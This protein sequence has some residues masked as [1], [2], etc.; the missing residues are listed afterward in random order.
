M[1]NNRE[2]FG[3]MGAVLL[4]TL[5]LMAL[6]ASFLFDLASRAGLYA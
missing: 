5:Y 2:F 6:D 1:T 3:A 4:S